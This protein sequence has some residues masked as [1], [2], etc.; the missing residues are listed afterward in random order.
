MRPTS[1]RAREAVFD[2]LAS[3]G[4]LERA[5]VADLFAGSGAMGIEALSRGARSAVF[6]DDRR[7]AALCVERN[8][9]Q[10]G[11]SRGGILGV[12]A[13]PYSTPPP[14]RVAAQEDP[15]WTAAVVQVDALRWASSAQPVDVAFCDP[16]YAYDRWAGLLDRLAASVVV[17]ESDREIRPSGTAELL[18]VRRYGTTVVTLIQRD[19]TDGTSQAS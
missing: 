5:A 10:F 14:G 11:W 18:K 2:M 9:G 3:L 1:E 19:P 12:P 8:L 17:A 13:D 16:P 7:E 6:V 4:V 15:R